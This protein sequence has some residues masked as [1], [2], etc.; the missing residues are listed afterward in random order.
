M[1]RISEY[2]KFN[3]KNL[4]NSLK[5]DFMVSLEDK[6]FVKLVNSLDVSEEILIKNAS[7][8]EKT[9]CELKHCDKCNGLNE[10]KNETKG[11]VNYPVEY[12]NNLIFSLKPCK[13]FKKEKESKSNT[14]FFETPLFLQNASLSNIYTDDKA[15]IKV[16]KYIKDFYKSFDNNRMKGLYLYGSFGSGKSYII[17]ALLNELSNKYKNIKVVS[18]YFPTLI[19]KLKESFGTNDM[20]FMEDLLY[21]DVLLIDDLGAEANSSWSRDEI[22]GSILQTRMDNNLS[23]FITSNYSKKDLEEHF[24]STNK[25]YDRIASARIMERIDELTNELELISEN[26]RR[27]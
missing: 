4:I 18:I 3:K 13:Y 11:Y 27:M 7:D 26:R 16:I 12:Q 17:S 8:L 5:V 2:K 25:S 19:L 21:A 20:S 22:L 9:V 6:E 15:R 10:C 14:I 23:T 24:A 1:K